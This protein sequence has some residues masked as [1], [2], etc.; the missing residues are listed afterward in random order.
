MRGA[1]FFVYTPARH[2]YP[3]LLVIFKHEFN[4]HSEKRTEMNNYIEPPRIESLRVR[5]YRALKDIYFQDLT[6]LTVL[7]GPNGSGKSTVFD[8]FAFL[9]ECFTEGLR[10]AWDR[11]GRFRELRSRD[12]DGAIVIELQYRE[13]PVT[14]L[15]TY[16]LEIG[17]ESKG[18]VVIREF[19]RWKRT[20]PGAPFYFLDY[21]KGEG[22]VISGEQ[23][24][25]KDQRID[26]PLAGPD[27][28]AVNTLGQL[29]ENPRVIAL[30]E[31]ITGWHLS[32]LSAEAA[33]GRPEAGAEERLSATGDNLPNVIQYLADQ[34]PERL[35]RIFETLRR[36]I[37]RIEKVDSRILDDG[38][39]LLQVKDAPFSTPIL[40]RFA[41]DG[42]L[43][44]LAYLT[45]LYD[46]EPPRL[47]G[48]EEPENY[49]HPRLLPELAEECVQA[50]ERTQLIVTT[51][52][53][54]FINQLRASQ[55]RVLYRD[56]DGYTRSKRIADM[57]GVTAMLDAGASLGDLW[58]EGYFEVGDPFASGEAG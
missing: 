27:V 31:F 41:S 50:A 53:P 3:S 44:M 42:T 48:I 10:K 9:S 15:I 24:E 52:S 33:R 1:S 13:R 12:C 7:L 38:R 43:K 19:L 17:E 26:K 37:P 36:R 23:P 16:H 29:A 5:N 2:L 34:Y 14:P 30:R 25:S 55:V 18:P 58:M 32:Y 20:H 21:R 35:E 54:F 56:T 51:H 11:R 47:I 39:L 22:K 57:T 45:L 46:P 4:K 28:L 40:A 6:P 49:L 8:V